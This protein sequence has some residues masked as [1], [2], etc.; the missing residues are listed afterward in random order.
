MK[1]N[2][3]IYILMKAEIGKPSHSRN[4]QHLMTDFEAVGSIKGAN[5]DL[6]L[7]YSNFYVPNPTARVPFLGKD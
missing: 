2:T 1:D 6:Y 5:I 3:G 7:T 4:L